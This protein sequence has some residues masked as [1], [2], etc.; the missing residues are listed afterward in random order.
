MVHGNQAARLRAVLR[1]HGY[2]V[3]GSHL[4]V[5]GHA[6]ELHLQIE[7]GVRARVGNPPELPL[8]G[9]HL[10]DGGGVG[11]DRRS[12][13]GVGGGVVGNI[14]YGEV[15]EGNAVGISTGTFHEVVVGELDGVL[16]AYHQDALREIGNR[17]LDVFNAVDDQCSGGA[18][19]ERVFGNSVHVG[20][21]PVKSW[22]LVFWKGHVVLKG[23]TGIDEGL[24]DL[25]G[26][27]RGGS[28]GAMVVNVERGER[29]LRSARAAVGGIDGHVERAGRG[30]VG[31]GD[32]EV[33][34]GFHMQGGVFQA[35]GGHE[36]KQSSVGEVGGGLIR[37]LDGQHAILT[38]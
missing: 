14:V 2:A 36:A 1:V 17:G 19:E 37:E 13:G 8:S 15:L 27:A 11:G 26:V 10:K 4:N 32:D 3:N 9:L 29:H 23:L 28:V 16:V 18:A 35:A 7:N 22:G 5:L 38:E 21:I 31:H 34:A 30:I 6:V 20:V 12:F 24:D 33:V 25:I